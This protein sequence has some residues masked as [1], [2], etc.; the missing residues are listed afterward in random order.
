MRENTYFASFCLP[1]LHLDSSRGE[2]QDLAPHCW[3]LHIKI[4]SCHIHLYIEYI[5]FCTATY[6]FYV[7]S[8]NLLGAKQQSQNALKLSY[9][10]FLPIC[11]KI[12][13]LA[14]QSCPPISGPEQI[15]FVFLASTVE[16][17]IEDGGKPPRLDKCTPCP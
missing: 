2:P 14:L 11:N 12:S 4:Y 15:V 1:S 17:D 9:I 10:W 5:F 13:T 16:R 3:D 8:P 6:S 7:N